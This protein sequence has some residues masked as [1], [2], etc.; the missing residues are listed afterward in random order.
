M[1]HG[2]DRP[3]D[4][5]EPQNPVESPGLSYYFTSSKIDKSVFVRRFR[6]DLQ[7]LSLRS[8]SAQVDNGAL[9]ATRC[10]LVISDDRSQ[11]SSLPNIKGPLD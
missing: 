3:T 1:G 4:R 7:L 9:L 6:N 10:A 2:T 11:G 8:N 5:A